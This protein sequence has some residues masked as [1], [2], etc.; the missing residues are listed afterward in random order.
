M[1]LSPDQLR[2]HDAVLAWLRTRD[3]LLTVGGL[4]GTGKTTVLSELASKFPTPTAYITPTGR[5]TSVLGR[6][7]VAAGTR[8]TTLQRPPDGKEPKKKWRHLFDTSLTETGGPPLCTT[9]HRLLLRPVI[10]PKTE[11]LLGWKELLKLD[12]AYKLIVAD[13]CF[14]YEQRVLT[15][16]GWRTIGF[17][18]T[19]EIKC[20]V[21]S[22]NKTTDS[23]ELKP[24]VRWLKKPAPKSLLRIDAGRTD[25]R[26][27][28]RVIRCTPTHKIMTPRGYVCAGKLQVGDEL[29]VRGRHLTSLQFSMMVGSMLGDAAM[30]RYGNRN[31]PQPVFTQ[32]DDQIEWLKFKRSIF[33]EDMAGKLVRG[34]SGYGPKPV[35][36]FALNVTDQARRVAEQMSLNKSK[37]NGRQYWTP[38]DKFLSWV[39]EAA[40]AFWY[41]D[42]GSLG[43]R[44]GS[45]R[46][47]YA[48][49][50]TE[51][52]DK[53]TNQRLADFLKRRFGL[54]AI[55]S[56]DSRG[57]FYLRFDQENA[58]ELLAIV[59]PFVP[60][61][62]ARKAPGGCFDPAFVP[63]G[64]TTVAPIR[65]IGLTEGRS[66]GVAHVYDLEVA[67]NHNYIAGNIV[68]SNCS[69]IS[70]RMLGI[71]QAR[72]VPVLAVGDHG[73]L[74]PVK[75]S[76]SLMQNPMLRLEQIH[77]QAEGSSII[78]LARHVREGGR[79]RDFRGWDENCVLR[80]RSEE[81][82][83]VRETLTEPNRL[84]VTFIAWANKTRVRI[85]RLARQLQG[86]EGPPVPG[87]PVVALHNYG[88]VCNGMRGLVT[89]PSFLDERRGWILHA[90]VA[91][92]DD[93]MAGEWH[94][95]N[96]YQFN[97]TYP[98]ASLDELREV[99]IPTETISGGGRL[100]DFSYCLTCHKAQGSQFDHVV[101]VYERD[102]PLNEEARRWNYTAISRASKKV[103]IL[104]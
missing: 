5:A 60:K 103:S 47:S 14:H 93:G 2:V 70:D 90:H 39:D 24:I 21:W 1:D 17:L 40:L 87:E 78:A 44:T 35:W 15:E 95:I 85:N 81:E 83:V 12:R 79:L 92:P 71:L 88:D 6:K 94:E 52:F 89:K 63:A 13:E 82:A 16:A 37:K 41:L 3:P 32:G 29:I 42:D 55:V 9:Y 98:F 18:V 49:L 73:Q 74:S 66:Y 46:V 99:G 36:S 104:A 54:R 30:K 62:M 91:F 26:R 23:M 61:C 67:D 75:E 19:N 77:R 45:G 34:A 38:T 69:M 28:A 65:S 101:V 72:G 25:S 96:A 4:G 8:I 20:R 43:I 31:S 58:H 48:S 102:Q 56:H 50:H 7:L 10:D 22:Y 97:R 11:E 68:V 27:D 57:Y 76:G 86:Y 53:K 59:T 80:S 64:E 100:F 51:C 84:D 33:G